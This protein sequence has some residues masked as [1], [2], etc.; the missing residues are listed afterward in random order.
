MSPHPAPTLSLDDFDYTLPPRLIAARPAARRDD[1]R[2]LEVGDKTTLSKFSALPTL[3]RPGDLL[4]VNN[5][6]VLPARLIG[7]KQSGGQ[8]EIF[9]ERFLAN[10]EV[11]AQIR[12][13]KPPK[14]GMQIFANGI[15]IVK[16]KTAEGFYILQAQNRSQ[17]ACAARPRFMKHGAIPLPPYIRRIADEEDKHRYQTIFARS[18]GSVAAPTAGLHFT[19]Q[20]FAELSARNIN[21]TSIT[22]HVG[23]GTFLPLRQGLDSQ[24]HSERYTI[25]ATAAAAIAATK[26][27]GGRV[28]AVGTTVLR[29]LESA[30]QLGDG[31][32]R[33]T[34]NETDLFIQPGFTFRS[35]DMLL[36][37]FHLPRSSLLVLVCTF[38]GRNRV[39]DAYKK[40]IA[41]KF[42]FYSYGDAMLLSPDKSS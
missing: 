42:R 12:A 30:A 36:T 35:A 18:V 11:L 9:A 37:N 33:P 40:A 5:S 19:P 24:L 26:K 16:E 22:L 39:L 13:S 17:K 6:R 23:A 2:L 25:S 28:I 34:N 8:V 7:N 15:F 38:G 14:I 41:A 10:G 31:N 1:S 29:A 4:V 21:K 27:R 32:I 20:T 3:L